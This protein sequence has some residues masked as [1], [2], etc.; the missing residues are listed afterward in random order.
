MWNM[1]TIRIVTVEINFLKIKKFHFNGS[2]FKQT[3]GYLFYSFY[4][5]RSANDD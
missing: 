3:H 5:P 2:L 4:Q 1:Y